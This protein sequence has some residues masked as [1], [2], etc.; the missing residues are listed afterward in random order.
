LQVGH[1]NSKIYFSLSS[2]QV[3][4]LFTVRRTPRSI[5]NAENSTY[6]NVTSQARRQPRQRKKVNRT[7]QRNR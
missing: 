6:G 2:N 5:L 7:P 3:Q 1:K 4:T